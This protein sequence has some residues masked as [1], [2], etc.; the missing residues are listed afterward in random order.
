MKP[1]KRNIKNL[2]EAAGYTPAMLSHIINGIR[3]PSLPGAMRLQKASGISIMVWGSQD[4]FLIEKEFLKWK[5]VVG[6]RQSN[7]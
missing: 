1:K 3:T 4:K 5:H 6:K 2:A 7:S